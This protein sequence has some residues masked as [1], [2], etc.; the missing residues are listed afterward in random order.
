MWFW[1]NIGN[2]MRDRVTNWLGIDAQYADTKQRNRISSMAINAD[3]YFGYHRPQFKVR[4]G[5]AN[6]NIALN[7]IKLVVDRS[8]S[9]MLGS[10]IEFDLPGED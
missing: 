6:D 8:V 7:F 9:L 4:V 3:Y 10:G 5:Q 1:G 2:L